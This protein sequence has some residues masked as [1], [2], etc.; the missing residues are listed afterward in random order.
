MNN[1]NN[2]EH[3][4]NRLGIGSWLYTCVEL[5]PNY[6]YV[7]NRRS[8]IGLNLQNKDSTPSQIMPSH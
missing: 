4:K 8:A 2:F 3:E 5:T 6:V 1:T 7:Y